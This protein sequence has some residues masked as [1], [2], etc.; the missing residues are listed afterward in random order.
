[1]GDGVKLPE[2]ERP[3]F[4]LIRKRLEDRVSRKIRS[5]FVED[6]QND[7][8]CSTESYDS[9][10]NVD[11]FFTSSEGIKAHHF[12]TKLNLPMKD[13]FSEKDIL[14]LLER[15][16][17]EASDGHGDLTYCKMLYNT[18]SDGKQLWQT[19]EKYC[20]YPPHMNRSGDIY[21]WVALPFVPEDCVYFLP[22]PEFFGAI[23]V[24]IDKFG[25]FCFANHILKKSLIENE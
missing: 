3:D 2:S 20:G 22:D 12:G 25:A 4:N 9:D 11:T 8:T 21:D 13:E 10:V 19:F 24:N 17:V 15:A 7:C 18:K 5:L 1:M 23:S 6:I 16:L 14:D